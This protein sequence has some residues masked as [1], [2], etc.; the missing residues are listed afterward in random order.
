MKIGLY[1]MAADILHTGHVT[2]LE[3]ARCKCDKLIVALHV[4]PANKR[5]TQTVYERYMQLRAV[6]YVDEIIPYQDAAD[7]DGLIKSLAFDVYFLG[8]DYIGKGF[9]NAETLA[10]LDKEIIYLRRR[11]GYSSTEL[12]KRIERGN[13][14]GKVRSQ[15]TT[16][17]DYQ[18]RETARA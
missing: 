8:E 5:L 6:R 15:R 7:L 3:E 17:Q 2:A 13:D 14:G 10:K 4:S 16:E 18:I 9:D 12:K 1:P 11:H